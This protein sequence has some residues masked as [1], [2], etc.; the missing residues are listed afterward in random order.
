MD[1]KKI[2]KDYLHK[3]ELL[4]EYNKNYY[5][6]DKPIV[7]DQEYDLLKKE[8]IDLENSYKFLNND[9]SNF[10]FY[11]NSKEDSA[12]MKLLGKDWIENFKF[13]KLYKRRNG[14][15]FWGRAT[16]S[17]FNIGEETYQIGILE[18]ISMQKKFEKQ[19]IENEAKVKS[20]FNSTNICTS[21]RC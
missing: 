2:S 19:L 9:R 5:D 10:V 1:K 15:V 17:I 13:E 21:F 6:K 20:I 8:I 16:R 14:D 3:I 4:E 18:D 12:K 11:E 7:S